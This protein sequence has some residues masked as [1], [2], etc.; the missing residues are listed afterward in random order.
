MKAF[1]FF[2]ILL[3]FH[4]STAYAL[5]RCVQED[6]TVTYSDKDCVTV[7]PGSYTKQIDRFHKKTKAEGFSCTAVRDLAEEVTQM[8]IK[9]LSEAEVYTT[10]GGADYVDPVSS[11]VISFVFEYQG[12]LS[13]INPIKVGAYSYNHCRDGEFKILQTNLKQVSTQ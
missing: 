3:V 2:T 7:A 6:G 12:K 5:N 4:T 10:L 8:M 11:E 13:E 1:W 9:G